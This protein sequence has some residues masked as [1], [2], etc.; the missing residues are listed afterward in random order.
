NLVR[1]F[2][3]E[4]SADAGGPY[5]VSER[6]AGRTLDDVLKMT[7]EQGRSLPRPVAVA[8][9][10]EVLR[11]LAH[12]HGN[13][14]GAVVHGGVHPRM[15]V[16]AKALATDPAK[17]YDDARVFL[18]ALDNVLD[19]AGAAHVAGSDIV[20]FLAELFGEDV[21]AAEAALPP[22]RMPLAAPKTDGRGKTMSEL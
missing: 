8:I 6:R 7:R 14:G 18:A 2:E 12:L 11:G 20:V 22:P 13:A 15:D 3:I 17:R 1:V 19:R 21:E 4:A 10:R 16:I 5:I 9:A